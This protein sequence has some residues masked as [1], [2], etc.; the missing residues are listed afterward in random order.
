MSMITCQSC[1]QFIDSDDDPD[2]FI[3]EDGREIVMCDSCRDQ[4][5]WLQDFYEQEENQ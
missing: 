3:T 5:E 2:C 1:G 4:A